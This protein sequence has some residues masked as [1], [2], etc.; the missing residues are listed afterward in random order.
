MPFRVF[1]IP[2]R[3][4]AEGERELNLFLRSHRVLAVERQFHQTPAGEASW[5]FCVEYLETAE[6]GERSFSGPK[7]DYKEVL[8]PEEFAVF[9]K[10]RVVRKEAAEAEKLPPFTLFSNE[11]LAEMVQKRVASRAQLATI[12][13]VGEA[14]LA[15]YGELV[16]KVLAEAFGIPTDTRAGPSSPSETATGR[17]G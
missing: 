17:G 15:K 12:R 8:S 1:T 5:S 9:S 14:R 11:Q 2:V 3:H 4:A 7:V 10:L 6:A 13:G 16:L